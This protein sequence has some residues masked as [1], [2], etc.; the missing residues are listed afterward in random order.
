[1][2]AMP[3]TTRTSPDTLQLTVTSPPSADERTVQLGAMPLLPWPLAAALGGALAAGVG[4]MLAVGVAL[5]A[6]FT[7]LPMPLPE[8]LSVCSRLWLLAHGGTLPLGN[9]TVTL[10]PLGLTALGMVMAWVAARF[11]G[12]HARLARPGMLAAGEKA[13]VAAGTAALVAAGYGL[14]AAVMVLASGMAPRVWTPVAVAFAVSLVGA[15][16]GAVSGVRLR[17]RDIRPSW[18]VAPLGGG[19]AGG[20]GLLAAGAV[21]LGA[22]TLSGA[23]RIE[24]LDQSLKLDAAGSVVWASLAIAYLPNALL[25]GLSWSLGGGFTVG[26][27]SLVSLSGTQLG[28][29]PAIPMLGALPAE[30]VAPQ[31]MAFWMITGVLAGMGAGVAAVLRVGKPR[32]TVG[33]AL[34]AVAVAAVAGLVTAGFLV[35]GAWASRGDLG[36]LRL[37]A[38]GP[39]LPELVAI[40]LPLLVISSVLGGVLCWTLGAV[41]ARRTLLVV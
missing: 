8:L 40:G 41:R 1:M 35:I 22:A 25:W 32:L 2:V 5:V 11:A 31:A 16:L 20:L 26:T 24:A 6:W 36:S 19:L 21:V 34:V 23:G 3:R 38:L 17:S 39:R 14:V 7:A 37:V 13:L 29:L 27:G 9:T 33:S 15:A 18:A 28:M 12:G 4:W 10:V 30:G